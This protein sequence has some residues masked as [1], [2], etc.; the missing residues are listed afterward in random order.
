MAYPMYAFRYV[1]PADRTVKGLTVSVHNADGW[2][3]VGK[4]TDNFRRL[5]RGNFSP[6][7]ADTVKITVTDTLG[8]N[9]AKIYEVRIYE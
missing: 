4:I 1:P 7:T 3:T 5:I 9:Y 8:V 6:I 2:H